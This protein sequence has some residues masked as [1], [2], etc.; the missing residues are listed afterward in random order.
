MEIAPGIHLIPGTV[1]PRPLQLSL[2]VGAE[3]VVLLDTG[4]AGDPERFIYPTWQPRP[5]GHDVDLVINTH[6]DS[7]HC[8]GNADWRRLSPRT[9]LTCGDAD[10][11]LIEDPAVMWATRYNAYDALHGIH[12]DDATHVAT[13]AMLGAAQPIDFT[14]RGGET[15]RLGPDWSV[16][17]RAVPGHTAGHLAVFDPRSRTACGRR[18]PRR[19]PRASPASG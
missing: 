11:T 12:Y 8:G 2:L 9:L 4:C 16:E 1:G 14:W 5:P 18:R 17:L 10:R 15:L 13:L 19:G 6:A 3:R 7:D